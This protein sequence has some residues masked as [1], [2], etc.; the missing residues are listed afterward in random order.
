MQFQR[1]KDM[2]FRL[3]LL[4]QVLIASQ[5]VPEDFDG[6]RGCLRRGPRLDNFD[7]SH[8]KVLFYSY[9]RVS[10]NL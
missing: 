2:R 10:G 7:E 9:W 6:P 5:K 8:Q 1:L 3:K 4:S